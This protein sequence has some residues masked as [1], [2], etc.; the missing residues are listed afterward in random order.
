M[1]N[2]TILYHNESHIYSI[3]YNKAVQTFHFNT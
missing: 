3:A 1:L 2:N